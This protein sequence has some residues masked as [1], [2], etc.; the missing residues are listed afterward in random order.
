MRDEGELSRRALLGGLV[1]AAAWSLCGD[2]DAAAKAAAKAPAKPTPV[3]QDIEQGKRGTTFT[4]SLQHSMFPA[5]GSRWRSRA[6]S[7]P[8]SRRSS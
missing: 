3:V 5:P 2:A 8:S 7:W 4:L 6:R 1:G